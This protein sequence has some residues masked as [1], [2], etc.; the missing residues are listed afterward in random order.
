ML[1]LT[2]AEKQEVLRHLD[3][4]RPLPDRYRFLLFREAGRGPANPRQS[5]PANPHSG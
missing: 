1:Q 5:P 2:D 3:E 4:G